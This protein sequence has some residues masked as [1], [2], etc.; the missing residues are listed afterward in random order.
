MK[1]TISVAALSIILR[2]TTP[3]PGAFYVFTVHPW[4]GTAQIV[5]SGHE[6]NV[7]HVAF[8]LPLGEGMELFSTAFVPDEPLVGR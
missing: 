1:M 7:C 6:T 3:G 4:D 8:R 2:F 5:A